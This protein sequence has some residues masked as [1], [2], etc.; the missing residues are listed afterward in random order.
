VAHLTQQ[1]SAVGTRT[2]LM[3]QQNPNAVSVRG[4]PAEAPRARWVF[5][6]FD[7]DVN[8]ITLG[9]TQ[10]LE[11]TCDLE[12][13]NAYRLLR[14]TTI[15]SNDFTGTLSYSPSYYAPGGE[16]AVTNAYPAYLPIAYDSPG[17]SVAVGNI[18]RTRSWAMDRASPIFRQETRVTSGPSDMFIV[19]LVTMGDPTVAIPDTCKL[20]FYAELLEYGF[21]QSEGNQLH[22]VVPVT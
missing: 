18:S 20:T 22:S 12:D 15:L 4:S 14:A 21:D 13:S 17:P 1:F 5:S 3:P 11:I 10:S 9:N 6:V 19:C 16:L 2:P 7:E 8:A